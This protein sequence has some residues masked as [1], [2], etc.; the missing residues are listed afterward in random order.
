MDLPEF[1]VKANIDK[2][3]LQAFQE[4]R[5]ISIT[6]LFHYLGPVAMLLKVIKTLW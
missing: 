1:W 6:W 2:F 4:P 5:I 3:G